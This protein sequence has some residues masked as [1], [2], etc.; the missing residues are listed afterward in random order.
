MTDDTADGQAITEIQMGAAAAS[1]PAVVVAP[2]LSDAAQLACQETI[3]VLAEAVADRGVAHLA[4][5]GGSGG[6]ALAESLAPL[7]ADQPEPVRHGIHL[8]FGDERFVPAGDPERNDLLAEP[9]VAAGVPGAQVHRLAPPQDVSGLDEATARMVHEL[10][11]SGLTSGGF[12]VVHVGLG[13]DAHV[14]SLFPGHPAALAVGI[15]AVAVRSSPKPPPERYSLTFE[16]LQRARRIMVVA[17]G[18]AKAEAVRLGLGAPDVV[19]APAS[20]CRGRQ[21]TWYLDEP[22]AANHSVV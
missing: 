7:V 11:A 21:T 18:A 13:P 20:C 19:T 3:R 6:V 4:L 15:A 1:E 9:L 8:W 2:T 22:A 5:T 14:C 16:V 12:D 17:G 10:E